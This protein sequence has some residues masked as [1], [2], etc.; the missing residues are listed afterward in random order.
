MKIAKEIPPY[1]ENKNVLD[2]AEHFELNSE[3]SN[4]NEENKNISFKIWL[5]WK[6]LPAVQTTN[7]KG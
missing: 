2:N 7:S 4:L 6:L 5:P 3:R 1:D